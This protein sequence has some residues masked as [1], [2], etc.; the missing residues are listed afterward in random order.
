[1]GFITLKDGTLIHAS[2]LNPCNIKPYE[3]KVSII[4]TDKKLKT[5]VIKGTAQDLLKGFIDKANKDR[6]EKSKYKDIILV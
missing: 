2:L 4:E 1:M 5:I 6:K 3:Y